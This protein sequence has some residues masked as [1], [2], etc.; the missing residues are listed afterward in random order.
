[1]SRLQS[2]LGFPLPT[3]PQQPASPVLAEPPSV[4]AVP[5]QPPPPTVPP[6]EEPSPVAEAP[7]S[8][9]APPAPAV[10]EGPEP[11]EPE[12][13]QLSQPAPGTVVTWLVIAVFVAAFVGVVVLLNLL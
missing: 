8:P 10:Q 2:G 6:P 1:M 3:A 5:Q 13:D 11:F 12:T 7:P 4:P 9:E